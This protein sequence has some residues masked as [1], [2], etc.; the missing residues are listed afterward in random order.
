MASPRLLLCV[1]APAV[2]AL[3]GGSVVAAESYPN[4]PIRV[5]TAA[6]G[7]GNDFVGRLI[8]QGVTLPLGQPVI[9]DNRGGMAADIVAKSRPDGY[10]LLFYSSATWTTPFLRD[11]VSYDPVRDLTPITMATKAPDIVVVHPSVAV[12]SVHDLIALAKAKPGGLN[13][14]TGTLG[15]SPHLAAELFKSMAA[16]NIVRVPYKGTGPSLTAVIAGEV[17]LMFPDAGPATPHIRSGKLKPLAV[18]SA[19]PSALAPGLPTVAASGVPGYEA[20][21]ILGMFAPTG[22]P[23]AIVKRLHDET[24]RVLN[25]PDVKDRLFNAGTEVVGSTPAAFAAKM[26]SEIAKWGKVIKDAGIREQ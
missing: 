19:E 12:K 25:Q 21:S 9:I 23:A 7:G 16:V 14:A 11:G 8:A 1:F 17:Q 18:T 26:K 10:T 3:S 20:I 13:Y 22:T 4:K 6:A 2:V 24:V 5:V 15:A